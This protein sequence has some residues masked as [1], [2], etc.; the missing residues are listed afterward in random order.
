LTA[1]FDF[2][3]DWVAGVHMDFTH[4]VPLEDFIGL[5]LSSKF[6]IVCWRK[7]Y[8]LQFIHVQP[9]IDMLLIGYRG[10]LHKPFDPKT[11]VFV[12]LQV[13]NRVR[14]LI[15]TITCSFLSI[16]LD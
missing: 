9:I 14:A 3:L 13:R 12:A 16:D 1:L 8:V 5:Y 6:L 2:G 4:F 10:N 7:G 15:N 11:F